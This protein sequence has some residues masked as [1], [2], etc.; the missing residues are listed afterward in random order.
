MIVKPEKWF[1]D[2]YNMPLAF[3][4]GIYPTS[5]LGAVRNLGRKGIPAVVV[6]WKKNQA[7]FFSKY[8]KGLLCPHPK[9]HEDDYIDFLVKVGEQLP[10]KAVLFPTGDTETLALLRHRTQLE[11]YYHFTMPPYPVVNNFL[12]KKEFYRLLEQHNIA[13]PKTFFPADLKDATEASKHLRY[14]CIIKP[15]YPTYFRF[16]F[17]TKLFTASSARELLFYFKK[18]S[19]KNHEVIIQEIIPGDADSMHGFNAYYDKTSTP[20]GMFQYQRIREWPIGFG[21]GCYIQHV[22][23]PVLEQETTK[24]MKK[25]GYYGFVDAEFKRD[26]RN[27]IFYFIELNPRIWMQN[28]FPSRFG[29]NLPYLAYQDAIGNPVSDT[30]TYHHDSSVKWVYFLEDIFS[31]KA[32]IKTGKISLLNWIQAYRPGNDHAIFAWDDP[33]PFFALGCHSLR[34]LVTGFSQNDESVKNQ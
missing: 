28:S 6:D 11:K 5:N 24:L 13:Y 16:D 18:A 3:V 7:A 8:A 19:E 14:P 1:F 25:I 12:N 27:G 17:H 32:G 21:N 31:S 26:P 2:Q 34:P 4:L 9:N 10:M 22:S 15:V 30:A 20:H 33:V 23:E 29:C